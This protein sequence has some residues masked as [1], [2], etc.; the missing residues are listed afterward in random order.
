M[1]RM[2]GISQEAVAV[3]LTAVGSAS[4]LIGLAIVALEI[5]SDQR[6]ADRLFAPAEVKPPPDR[7][8]PRPAS[9]SEFEN[10][11]AP[12]LGPSPSGTQFARQV[13]SG[14]A[15]SNKLTLQGIELSLTHT[16]KTANK[17]ANDQRDQILKVREDL[18]EVLSGDSRRRVAGAAAI[19][20][21]ILLA[22]AGSILGNV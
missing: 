2:F 9:A 15:A 22:T 11:L 13:A 6:H 12:R 19:G 14:F 20:F 7:E 1:T 4:E 21:G 17:L 16:D 3:F 10:V 18:S 5:R 8:M